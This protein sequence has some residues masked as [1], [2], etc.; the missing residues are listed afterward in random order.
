MDSYWQKKNN[1]YYCYILYPVQ[2]SEKSNKVTGFENPFSKVT[3][4]RREILFRAQLV[5]ILLNIIW[6]GEIMGSLS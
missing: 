6:H 5:C 4:I 1:I 2:M 3:L